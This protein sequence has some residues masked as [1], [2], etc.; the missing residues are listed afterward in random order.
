MHNGMNTHTYIHR[1]SYA[2][3][4]TLLLATM[5]NVVTTGFLS[6]FFPVFV[7]RKLF[8]LANSLKSTTVQ[9]LK[10]PGSTFYVIQWSNNY[11]SFSKN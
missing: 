10:T 9:I 11:I 2:I 1:K 6:I 8:S 7:Q 4:S 3:C 5:T